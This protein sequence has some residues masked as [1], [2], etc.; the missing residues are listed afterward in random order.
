MSA[1][2]SGGVTTPG[3]P[4]PPLDA[5]TRGCTLAPVDPLV[6]ANVSLVLA[7]LPCVLLV[8]GGLPGAWML[9][10]LAAFVELADAWWAGAG[11]TSVGWG[12]IALGAFIA[13]LG[14]IVEF[15]SGSVGAKHGGGTRKGMIGAFVGGLVGALLCTFLIPVPV[16]GTLVG[17]FG[18]TFLGAWVGEISGD[19]GVDPRTAI[20]PALAAT[21]GRV[22]G[23][24]AKVGVATLV[25]VELSAAAVYALF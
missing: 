22:I 12:F 6:V 21:L 24:V 13:G 19:T 14:E 18:G 2:S 25:W 11:V 7:G 1:S 17:A 20:K 4:A 10:G 3:Y 15:L 5:A 16:I 8:M 23:T 9:L